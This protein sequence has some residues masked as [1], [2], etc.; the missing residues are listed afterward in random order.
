MRSAYREHGAISTTGM[1]DMRQYSTKEISDYSLTRA[2]R[3]AYEGKADRG[4]LEAEISTDLFRRTKNTLPGPSQMMVP[5]SLLAKYAKR[6][7]VTTTP[8]AGGYLVDTQNAGL[9]PL[10]RNRAVVVAMGAQLLEGLQSNTTL[11]RQ[12][13]A[14][15]FYWL[16]SETT[17]AQESQP[18]L[19]QASLTPKT[20]AAVV[21]ISRQLLVQSNPSVE[22][23]VANDLLQV[24]GLAMDIAALRG[25]GASGEPTGVIN[26]SGI[27][28]VA[29]TSID[30]AKT[31]EFQS[32][33][34][35]G[36]ALS[37]SCGYVT[38]PTVATLLMGRMKA[39]STY[40]PI[41]EG[42]VLDGQVC[43]FRAM[44]SSQ[45]SAGTMLFGDFSQLVIG[46]WGEGIE[47]DL[48]PYADFRAGIVSMRVM[49]SMD[50][51]VRQ[52]SAFS[53]A[54]SVT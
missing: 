35:A 47:L 15:T 38:T 48:N 39:A 13:G 40:S 32:D 33:V 25:S 43:G 54:S 28:S 51:A 29:A 12:T 21:E 1:A 36:N 14:S 10:L 30:L 37:A 6:D 50:V 24:A 17:Q 11:P 23:L 31:L 18:T 16:A 41:W 53:Y 2:L 9:I 26:T 4:S 5:S 7:L 44:S 22:G 46:L 42:S 20:G 19:A 49:V 52:P 27:G 8:S 34:A 3:A 45:M